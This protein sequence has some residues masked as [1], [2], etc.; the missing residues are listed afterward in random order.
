M[1]GLGDPFCRGSGWLENSS[2]ELQLE[3]RSAG[4][5]HALLPGLSRQ[6]QVDCCERL[7]WSK[8]YQDSQGHMAKPQPKTHPPVIT[9][10]YETTGFVWYV[11]LV[12]V[13]GFI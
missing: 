9:C 2:Q 8:Q 13:W 12:S 1:K 6:R 7:A 4:A 10:D 11:C 3:V 5:G